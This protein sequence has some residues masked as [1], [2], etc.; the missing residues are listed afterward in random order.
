MIP[1]TLPT[2]PPCSSINLAVSPSCPMADNN[3][4]DELTQVPSSYPDIDNSCDPPPA[5]IGDH[6]SATPYDP[7]P[8]AVSGRTM[9]SSVPSV[10]DAAFLTPQQPRNALPLFWRKAFAQKGSLFRDHGS[11]LQRMYVVGD[12][13]CATGALFLALFE[14][15]GTDDSLPVHQ[16][17]P[18]QLV[19]SLGQLRTLR[20]QLI[21]SV[22]NDWTDNDW[23]RYVPQELRDEFW[24]FEC[25]GGVPICHCRVNE[26]ICTRNA[27]TPTR[28]LTMFRAALAA[29]TYRMGETFFHVA[30]GVLGLNV[31]LLCDDYRHGGGR[32][33][34][35][36]VDFGSGLYPLSIILFALVT[37]KGSDSGHFESVGLALE[38]GGY[39]AL[40]RSDHPA[41]C[42]LRAFALD[43]SDVRTMDHE[44]V[45]YSCTMPFT[46]DLHS[47]SLDPD[48]PTHDMSDVA[49]PSLSPRIATV[50]G[51][52]SQRPLR[53][54]QPR[55]RYDDEFA[56]VDP[57]VVEKERPPGVVPLPRLPHAART[58]SSLSAAVQVNSATAGVVI[59]PAD[60][61]TDSSTPLAAADHPV[62][63]GPHVAAA[64]R[65]APSN[66]FE[67][68]AM[69][70]LNDVRAWTHKM[71]H[72]GQLA[73]RCHITM[74]P[75]W[76]LRCRETLQALYAA[77]CA[78]PMDELL[79]TKRII[80]LWVLP[81][82]VFTIPGKIRGGFKNR[83]AQ[84]RRIA[85]NLNDPNLHER[86]QGMVDELCHSMEWC[87]DPRAVD[88]DWDY[89]SESAVNVHPPPSEVVRREVE[90]S[91]L[92]TAD[93]EY[94][95]LQDRDPDVT[96]ASRTSRLIRLGH[97]NRAMQTIKATTNKADL[98]DPAERAAVAALHPPCTSPLPLLPADSPTLVVAH[99][100]MFAEMRASDS[101]AAPGV[102]GYASNFISVL[103]H[104]PHCVAALAH[105]VQQIVN[106]SL[107]PA[108]R[109]LLTTC[110]VV[111][112]E[113]PNSGRRPIAIG[114]MFYKFAARYAL[115]LVVDDA[116][117]IVQP[118]QFGMGQPDGCT[119][120]VQSLQHLLEL[121]P[122]IPSQ[123]PAP[124]LDNDPGPPAVP[125]A[126]DTD[127][128]AIRPF[129]CLSIDM[130]NAF[131]AIDRRAV[132]QAVYARPELA[133]CWRVVDFAYGHSS[134]LLMKCGMDVP[135]AE[136]F[137]ESQSGVRQGDPLSAMLFGLAMHP[138]YDEIAKQLQGGVFAFMD[139]GHGVG[140]LQQCWTIWQQL[141][142]LLAPLQLSVNPAKCELTCFHLD[143]LHHAGDI[144]ALK[145]FEAAGVQINRRC[146]RL[147]GCVVGATSADIARE[148][149]T[150]P[151]FRA[152]SRAAYSRLP[153][154]PE[155]H[156]C[157]V[158][159]RLTSIVVTNR[160]RAMA[161]AATDAHATEYDAQLLAA[162]HVMV[163]VGPDD[164]NA[165]DAQLQ[166]PA[167]HGGFGLTSAVS[168]APAA[169]LSGAECTLRLSPVFVEVW[170]GTKPLDPSC[171]LYAGIADSL[172]RVQRTE[173]ALVS[174]SPPSVVAR[175]TASIL[176]SCA[177][178]FVAH[179]KA[180]HAQS[181][182]QH[183]VCHR[184]S[185]LS[186]IAAKAIAGRDRAPGGPVKLARLQALEA[187]QSSLWLTTLPT[188]PGLTLTCPQWRIAARLRL[189]LP[190]NPSHDIDSV[191]CDHKHAAAGDSW[192]PLCCTQRCG[193]DITHRHNR[194]LHDLRDFASLAHL[195][196]RIE[197]AELH[198]QRKL[199]PDI[200]VHLPDATLLADVTVVHPT[201]KCWTSLAASERGVGA[202]GDA[203]GAAKHDTY[204][205]L[206]SGLSCEFLPFVLYTYGGFHDSAR[207]FIHRLCAS[208]DPVTCL[209]SADDWRM[210]VQSQIAVSVQ[211]GNADIM[212][213]A[214]QRA[215]AAVL[216]SRRVRVRPSPLPP[217]SSSAL[218]WSARSA[219]PGF[220]APQRT[221][222]LPLPPVLS[223]AA[224]SSSGAAPPSVLPVTLSAG[225]PT[226]PV[227]GV[228][229]SPSVGGG[230]SVRADV[231]VPGAARASSVLRACSALDALSSG[232]GERASDAR[233]ALD[234]FVGALDA[235]MAVRSAHSDSGPTAA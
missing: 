36:V 41:V 87:L 18:N 93:L 60:R 52:L 175:V 97:L 58:P 228:P 223:D 100:W 122:Q 173:A 186:T 79:V 200:Q 20:S 66:R 163:G 199:R 50:R 14:P 151:D 135:A 114:D 82:E 180:H 224:A 235:V 80:A 88:S 193:A 6:G 10:F 107:P 17:P 63:H 7:V 31:L 137:L 187:R 126:P 128:P 40:F 56:P 155:P 119:Q 8:A 94:S 226:S 70:L 109:T 165:F 205:E 152:E 116:R 1:A 133:R 23:C 157:F 25:G 208:L 91:I 130:R 176:P 148:L 103:A 120:I 225:V 38:G 164:G 217:P 189:G 112:L 61:R 203:A 190:G 197:P 159:R 216:P 132:L 121:A 73:R 111:S 81:Q 146:L 22:V 46:V 178:H 96:A 48:L 42:A 51:S 129:A 45:D 9:S 34:H 86:V 44:R 162:A 84:L 149:A 192:H 230:V 158:L 124:N 233:S 19:H 27:R 24:S 183:S 218:P 154:M 201:A 85:C 39:A 177:E 172:G 215:R 210:A 160:L 75:T 168:V 145:A 231:S 83:Q 108:V 13:S 142:G 47:G 65:S 30:A 134:P 214:S 204:D 106:N 127:N 118:H 69:Q 105:F 171:S 3:S 143:S 179:F 16:L 136:A 5:P 169:Y 74:V 170:S 156:R 141:S 206:A 123:R 221:I 55:L 26:C 62:A 139:D 188:E 33:A 196:V 207:R 15:E 99:E 92:G 220:C 57:P 89:E 161:P 68:T 184:I 102:S 53:Q 67:H 2:S 147:L 64:A 11:T 125:A 28:E 182:I 194:I 59:P 104:D 101:G 167:R 222:S 227:R 29:P 185:T 144:A 115:T 117:R 232:M 191:S 110:L 229:A 181:L 35:R 212:I 32:V 71:A 211:R 202:V 213:G 54:R 72:R 198:A 174:Q 219:S 98:D 78:V 49:R 153:H 4:T 131:N 138:V 234:V 150:H 37:N 166:Q 95:S 21:S 76:I 209:V 90:D 195:P 113:K 140:Y 43:K 77:L 12:G